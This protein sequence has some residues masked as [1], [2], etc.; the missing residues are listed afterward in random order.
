MNAPNFSSKVAF[1]AL[2]VLAAAISA[3]AKA[4]GTNDDGLCGMTPNE[5]SECKPAVAAG[6]ATPPPPTAACCASLKHADVPC[7]CSFKNNK[8]LPLFGIDASRAMQLPTKC[9]PNQSAHC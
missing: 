5:L 6:S 3:T 1:V 4:A 9:D 8:Y 2:I 7:F